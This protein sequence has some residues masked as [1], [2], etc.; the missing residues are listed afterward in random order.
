[1][2]ATG[3]SPLSAGIAQILMHT[4]LARG[5]TLLAAAVI[6]LM[7]V[8]QFFGL[9]F[10]RQ[11]EIQPAGK[12]HSDKKAFRWRLPGDYQSDLMKRRGSVLENGRPLPN[13]ARHS[14]DVRERGDGW[15]AFHAGM[16]WFAPAD[17]T[18]PRTNG[19][20]YDVVLP[21]QLEEPAWWPVLA[22]MLLGCLIWLKACVVRSGASGGDDG[23]AGNNHP[24]ATTTLVFFAAL[25]ISILRVLLAPDFTDGSLTIKGVPE[26]DAGAWH[27]MT[28]GITEGR[29]LTTTFEAQRPMYAVLMSPAY[30]IFG[31]RILVAKILNCLCLAMAVAG[32]WAAGLLLRARL[33]GGMAALALLLD[34]AHSGLTHTLITENAGLCFAVAAVLATWLA[35]WHLSPRWCFA[36]GFINGIGNLASGAALLTLPLYAAAVWINPLVRLAP[37]RRVALMVLAFVLGATVVVLPWMIRQKA[38]HGQFTLALNSMELLYG[39]AH[40]E[41]KKL[42]RALHSEAEAAGFTNADPGARYRYF[43]AKFR[44]VAMSNP[45]GYARQVAA[46]TVASF[47]S[48]DVSDPAVRTAGVLTLLL[49]ALM[50]SWKSGGITRL[51]MAVA[52]IPTWIQLS[53]HLVFPVMLVLFILCWRRFRWPDQRLLLILIALT[54]LAV[55]LLNGLSGNIAPRRF[56][57]IGDWAVVLIVMAGLI[58][59][60]DAGADALNA[61]FTRMGIL[62]WLV[63]DAS[64][65]DPRSAEEAAPILTAFPASLA[66]WSIAAV[67]FSAALTGLG[68]KPSWPAFDSIDLPG[69]KESLI[70]LH[71]EKQFA[72]NADRFR[73]I[74]ASIDDLVV[75]KAAGEDLGHWLPQYQRREY[76]HWAAALVTFANDGRRGGYANAIIRGDLAAAPRGQPLAWL[77]IETEGIDRISERPIPLFEVVATCP[78]EMN[79]SG[80]WQVDLKRAVWFEPTPESLAKL[81]PN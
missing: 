64:R 32:V 8:Q 22:A 15:F 1:M 42:T 13:R 49:A 30:S 41:E 65:S 7:L 28:I 72:A 78:I 55:A 57:L 59:M 14:N 48:I 35:I 26:S 40:P 62:R 5:I 31:C 56:W 29:G 34:S 9:G 43:A 3:D 67:A 4:R 25:L 54:V 76:D 77:G 81:Q 17:G 33:A 70:K 38:V 75:H 51:L 73:I 36:A 46:A 21:K 68:S 24:A 66:L 44:E 11:F 52:I 16:V 27:E 6:G 20:R 45:L 63:A 10:T 2:E 69:A 23:R 58:K 12:I 39:G 19:R 71:P 50:G 61:V 80:R 60:I 74:I 37:G 53:A 79:P 18:D 47:T